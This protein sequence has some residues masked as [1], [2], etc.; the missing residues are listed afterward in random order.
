MSAETG[1]EMSIGGTVCPR[2]ISG[3]RIKQVMGY[4][5]NESTVLDG[6]LPIIVSGP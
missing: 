6:T 2:E 5:S 4:R 3:S 1:G